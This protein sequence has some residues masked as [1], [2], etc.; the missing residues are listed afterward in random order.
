M[1]KYSLNTSDDFDFVVIG[2]MSANNQYQVIGA[3]NDV[4]KINLQL[5]AFVPYNLKDGKLFNFSLY[6][7]ID[8]ELGLEYNVIPNQSN[9]E[10][11]NINSADSYDLFAN[12]EVEESVRLIKELPKT[13]YFIVLKGEDLHNYQFKIMDKLKSIDD[14]IQVQPV[15]VEELPSKRNLMF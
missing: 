5:Q 11:P 3:I 7:F 9:F 13:D 6:S 1:A 4:L 14:F 2:L 8:E 10:G 15:A 12:T